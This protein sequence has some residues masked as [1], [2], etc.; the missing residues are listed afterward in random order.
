MKTLH[1]EFDLLL[2]AV[3]PIEGA[4][5]R[6]LLQG[7]GIP[8]MLNGDDFDTAELGAAHAMLRHPDLF[9]PKGT[10]DA[11]RAI[12]VAAWGEARVAAHDPSAT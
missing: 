8:S 10:H 5:A 4:L 2:A 12:L 7:E 1:P 6:D 11:A 9:V 3:D